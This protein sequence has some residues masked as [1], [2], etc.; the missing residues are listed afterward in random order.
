MM[1]DPN[2]T[3]T[4]KRLDGSTFRAVIGRLASGVTVTTTRCDGMRFGAVLKRRHLISVAIAS[5]PVGLIGVAVAVA[6]IATAATPLARADNNRLNNGV[7]A[8]VYT[9]QRDAGCSTDIR[10]NPQLQR[11]AQRHTDDVLSNASL[12]GD[13]GSD[14]SSVQDRADAVGFR[15]RVTE[16]VAV[17]PALS[18]TGIE[19]L[20]QWFHNPDYLSIM[21]NCNNTQIGVWSANS[22]ARTVV[23]A[24]YGQPEAA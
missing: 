1:M 13:I 6:V 7:V 18:I 24:V 16:T 14:G 5:R 10:I 15:G 2:D 4:L 17:N 22:L 21:L 8:N 9:I 12:D 11:A 19:I 23:V 20:H 3:I